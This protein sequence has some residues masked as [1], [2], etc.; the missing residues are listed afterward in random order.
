MAYP[1]IQISPSTEELIRISF[2]VLWSASAPC[3]SVAAS[4]GSFQIRRMGGQTSNC[5]RLQLLIHLLV[6][7]N[8]KTNLHG[9]DCFVIQQIFSYIP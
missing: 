2:I 8:R 3:F 7:I 9:D 1:N 4:D 5:S 6:K